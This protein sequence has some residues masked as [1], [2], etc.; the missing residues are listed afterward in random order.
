[1][2][3]AHQGQ[4]RAPAIWMLQWRS[5][6]FHSDTHPQRKIAAQKSMKKALVTAAAAA[7]IRT[8]ARRPVTG[9]LPEAIEAPVLRSDH[10]PPFGDGRGCRERRS[11]LEVP[12]L[13]AGHQIEDVE[14]AVVGPDVD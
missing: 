9:L 14:V 3:P 4:C 7:K 1:M 2:P 11:R 10:Y 13:L 12:E 8:F 5:A 6:P